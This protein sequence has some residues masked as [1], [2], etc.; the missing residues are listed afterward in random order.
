MLNFSW[1]N[2]F[3]TNTSQFRLKAHSNATFHE[4]RFFVPVM[5]TLLREDL[6]TRL[7]LEV[8]LQCRI[9]RS[10]RYVNLIIF[11]RHAETTRLLL[12]EVAS[13]PY[14]PCAATFFSFS[15]GVSQ[16]SDTRLIRCNRWDTVSRLVSRFKFG[17]AVTWM[18]DE[19]GS[20]ILWLHVRSKNIARHPLYVVMAYV[21]IFVVVT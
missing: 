12:V 17:P 21:V 14:N 8:V 5:N 9:I 19:R 4:T 16:R 13:G 11:P 2:I 6:T 18:R 15:V 10:V 3:T 20:C 7:P 1:F